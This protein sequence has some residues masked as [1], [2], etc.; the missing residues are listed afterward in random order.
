MLSKNILANRFNGNCHFLLAKRILN[1][2]ITLGLISILVIC[3]SNKVIAQCNLFCFDVTVGLGDDC[4]DTLSLDMLGTN[5]DSCAGPFTFELLE[6]DQTPLGTDIIDASMI[7]MTLAYSVTDSSTGVSCWKF[8]LI[9]DGGGPS[10]VN[11]P[12]ND[13]LGC[14]TPLS[15]ATQLTPADVT[16]CSDFTITFSDSLIFNDS[17]GGPFRSEFLRTYL[18]VDDFNNVSTCTQR[19]FYE[20]PTLSDVTFP[21]NFT[22]DSSLICSFNLRI[23]SKFCFLISFDSSSRFFSSIS[24]FF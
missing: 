15:E 21:P 6:A 1:H 14:Y 10:I 7:G 18:V 19:I 8:I 5:V 11:C 20:L 3:T 13:T 16:D 23:Y 9:E 12:A 17:C 24:C 2:V 22:S 4:L